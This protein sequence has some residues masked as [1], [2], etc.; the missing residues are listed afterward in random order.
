M[1]NTTQHT[2]GPWEIVQDAP[3]N[4]E[5]RYNIGS[6]LP[7]GFANYVCTIKT[8]KHLIRDGNE[9]AN[10]RLIASAP[11]LLA[12]LQAVNTDVTEDIGGLT[13]DDYEAIVLSIRDT[14]R[15][16]IAKATGEEI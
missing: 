11:E 5:A 1:K 16:A 4:P 2:P 10:A 6:R 12:A 8:E 7:S 9:E 3:L 13:R 14:A 15:A